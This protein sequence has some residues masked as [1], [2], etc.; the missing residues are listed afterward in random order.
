MHVA[1]TQDLLAELLYNNYVNEKL[2]YY[3]EKKGPKFKSEMQFFWK[4]EKKVVIYGFEE[5][6]C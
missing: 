3:T 1:D 6:K 4:R 5:V 2:K